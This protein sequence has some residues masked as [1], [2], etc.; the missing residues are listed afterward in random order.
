LSLAQRDRAAACFAIIAN[1]LNVVCVLRSGGDYRVDHVAAL[2][3]GVERNLTIPHHFVCL[4][5]LSRVARNVTVAPLVHGWPGW[6]SKIELFRPD[7]FSYPVFYLDLDTIIVGPLDDL[8]LGHKFTV[9]Q[10]FWAKDRIGSG[11]MAWSYNLSWIYRKFCMCPERFMRDYQTTERW[12]DQGFIRFNSPIEPSRW[13]AKFPGRVVSYK[14]HVRPQG[15]VPE[16][17]SIIAFHGK[18]RPWQTSLWKG[19]E[20]GKGSSES[21]RA[22]KKAGADA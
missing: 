10:N 6:W 17:A 13:Q 2:R 15:K 4:T 12:G 11:L 1:M 9:L 5:D 16:G 20:H 3:D 18:P 14:F 8:V 22:D 19:A 21:Q 7:L